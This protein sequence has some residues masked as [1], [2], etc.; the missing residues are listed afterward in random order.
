MLTHG[1]GRSAF[2][3]A[4]I[5]TGSYIAAQ[6]GTV[7]NQFC[8]SL[9]LIGGKGIHR[10]DDQ[11]LDARLP[12]VLVAVFQNGIQKAFCFA[13]T[14]AGCNQCRTAVIASQ[15]F[16]RFLLMNIGKICRVN[17]LKAG[18]HFLCNTEGQTHGKIRL[19]INRAFLSKHFCNGTFEGSVAH[20]KCSF[21]VITNAFF[22][23][24]G[25]N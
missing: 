20:G 21:D 23:L 19:M 8:N 6:L 10:I 4:N 13:R 15:S 11:R 2:Q 3:T 7:M 17:C 22:E 25:K 5:Y 14:C 12:T 1:A 9:G 16:K 24:A 18:W